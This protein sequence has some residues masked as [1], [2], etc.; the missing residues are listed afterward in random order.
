MIAPSAVADLVLELN[1]ADET[2]AFTGSDT[3]TLSNSSTNGV[4][5][6]TL[7][8]LGGGDGGVSLVQYND[9]SVFSAS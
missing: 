9:A 4:V 5:R 6:W 2:F 3:G 8:S 7:G 1:T